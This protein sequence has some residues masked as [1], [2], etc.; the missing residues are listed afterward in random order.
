MDLQPNVAKKGIKALFSADIQST[1]E[2]THGIQ[3]DRREVPQSLQLGDQ[4]KKGLPS[5]ELSDA[6]AA[7]H[8]ENL[9]RAALCL[10]DGELLRLLV[11]GVDDLAHVAERLE[12]LLVGGVGALL[13]KDDEAARAGVEDA[14]ELLVQNHVRQLALDGRQRQLHERGDV[15]GLHCRVGLDDAA[16]VLLEQHVVERVEV[17]RDDLVVAQL[18]LGGGG[19]RPRGGWRWRR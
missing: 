18:R 12:R 5:S 15:R 9:A 11:E 1:C 4:T 2:E 14:A 19:G 7:G 17:A 6:C 13:V 16:N 10:G 8:A 3:Q